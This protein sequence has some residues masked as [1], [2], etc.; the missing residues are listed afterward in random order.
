MS[1]NT[2]SLTFKVDDVGCGLNKLVLGLG[3]FKKLAEASVTEAQK[4]TSELSRAA[5]TTTVFTAV[6]DAIRQFNSAVSELSAA[7]S[8]RISKPLDRFYLFPG[9][10]QCAEKSG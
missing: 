2:I 5:T 10:A 7:Y 1:A 3:E 6:S 4:L 8:V 9:G